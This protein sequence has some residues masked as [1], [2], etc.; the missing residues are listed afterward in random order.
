MPVSD[1]DIDLD[2]TVEV[3]WLLVNTVP[4]SGILGGEQ[5]HFDRL[6]DAILFV[7]EELPPKE[8]AT[9]WILLNDGSLQIEHIERLHREIEHK[10]RD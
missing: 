7:M 9:A 1:D 8:R 3:L 10:G 6:R 4:Q 2:Q 5:K